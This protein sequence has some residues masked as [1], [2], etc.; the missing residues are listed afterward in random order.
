MAKT[1]NEAVQG[2][3]SG[4]KRGSNK[5]ILTRKKERKREEA[6]ARNARTQPGNRRS[7]RRATLTP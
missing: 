5:G 3:R 1:T 2:M 6:E 7:A 4:N